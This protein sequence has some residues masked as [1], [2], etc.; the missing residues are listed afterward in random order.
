MEAV[1]VARM[2]LAAII[3]KRKRIAMT[4]SQVR[5][6]AMNICF[7]MGVDGGTAEQLLTDFLERDY[8]KTLSDETGLYR[9]YPNQNANTYLQ[10][11]VL[12][13][14]E[15]LAELD[16]YIARYAKG[17]Q[18]DRIS[19]VAVSVMRLAMFET[20]YVQ[21]VSAAVAINEAVELAKRYEDTETVAF[22]NGVLGSFVRGE[23]KK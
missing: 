22:I 10:Q 20:L 23:V 1:A 11:L 12:G 5:E 2:C 3:Y 4:R 7:A 19:R 18:I 14:G 8:Y 15:H 16:L 9:D 13:L 21:D 6:I 17:W